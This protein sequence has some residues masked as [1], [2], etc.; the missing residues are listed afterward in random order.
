MIR[1]LAPATFT[2]LLLA[3]CASGPAVKVDADP[4]ANLSAYRTYSWA[5]AEPPR[6]MNPLSYQRVR[7]SIDANLASRGYTQASPGDFAVG[8]TLGARDKV[9]VTD[10]GPYG[11]FYPGYG[12]G[13]R[14]GWAA[15]YNDVD[16]R[17]VT[18]GTLAIDIYDSGTKKPVWH[19]VAT[20][21][22]GSNVTQQQI[23]TAVSS[24]LA[25]FPAAAAAA[26]PN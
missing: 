8:F 5:Y 9:E 12:R 2:L 17:N 21:N 7:Q 18:E 15:P 11:G 1:Q 13:F 23:E 6:G 3:S 4:A 24:V 19:G 16:V 14:G 10:F 25:K 26:P 22:I 20:Q